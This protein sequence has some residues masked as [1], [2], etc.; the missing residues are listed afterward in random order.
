MVA[1]FALQTLT[2]SIS[3]SAVLISFNALVFVIKSVSSLA[4][5]ASTVLDGCTVGKVAAA[6]GVK[7][8]ASLAGLA[9]FLVVD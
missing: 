1:V 3:G 9:T 6:S 7:E 5:D 2:I 8:E 4:L